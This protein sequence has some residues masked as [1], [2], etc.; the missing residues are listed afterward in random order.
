[1]QNIEPF[2]NWRHIYISEDDERSPFLVEF[3]RNLSFPKLF[4]I[5]TSTRNGMTLAAGLYI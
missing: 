2:Y 4:I 1:M 3:I 5:F